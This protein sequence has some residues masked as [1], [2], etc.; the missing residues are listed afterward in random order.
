MNTKPHPVAVVLGNAAT[1]LYVTRELGRAGVQ[2]QGVSRRPECGGASKY[3]QHY[4]ICQTADQTLDYLLRKVANDRSKPVLI[5]ASDYYVD[6]VAGNA[7]LLSQHFSFQNSY[8]NG[9]AQSLVTK[10]S[11]YNNCSEHEIALPEWLIVTQ[12]MVELISEQLRFPVFIKPNKIHEVKH[13]MKGQKGWIVHNKEDL[14]RISLALPSGDHSFIAQEIIPGP[15]SNI[16][17]YCAYFNSQSQSCQAFTGR[18]LR[19]YPPGFGSASLVISEVCDE[20]KEISERFLSAMGFQGVAACEFKRDPRDNQL[21]LIEINPR[22]SLWFSVSNA[23]GKKI[24]LAA[25]QDLG[26]T[27]SILSEDNQE[28]RIGW[29][30]LNRDIYSS[31]FYA[32]ASDFVLPKPNISAYWTTTKRVD[33]VYCRVDLRPAIR[34]WRTSLR[35]SIYRC[36]GA[37]IP[38]D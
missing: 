34:E 18:K 36:F 30:Y 28:D 32:T 1:G 24:S 3:L 10:S 11:L 5:P 25:Y 13:K 20:A 31:Y 4:A 14:N 21:K 17:L 15:E 33:A 35:G 2:V 8:A 23:A 29:R 19:Q 22:P 37:N 27:G 26:D 7:S 16:F 38:S 6:F 9:L 12:N